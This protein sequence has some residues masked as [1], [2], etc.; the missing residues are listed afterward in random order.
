MNAPLPASCK[1]KETD[2]NVLLK[3]PQLVTTVISDFTPEAL[4]NVHQHNLRGVAYRS[5]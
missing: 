2:E 4:M 3:K 5:R 1:D